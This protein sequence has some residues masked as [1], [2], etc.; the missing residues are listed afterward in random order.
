MASGAK[1][2]GRNR[3][4]EVRPYRTITAYDTRARSWR[5][6]ENIETQKPPQKERGARPQVERHGRCELLG[7]S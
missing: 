1:L 4:K 5:R 7:R 6:N 2:K 3:N